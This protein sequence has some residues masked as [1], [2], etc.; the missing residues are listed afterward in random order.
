MGNLPPNQHIRTNDV[1]IWVVPGFFRKYAGIGKLYHQI[2][3]P[4]LIAFFIPKC[5]GVFR[6]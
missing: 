2:Q 6:F 5:D 1:Q 3:L 4:T